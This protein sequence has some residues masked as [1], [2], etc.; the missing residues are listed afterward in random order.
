MSD[1]KIDAEKAWNLLSWNNEVQWF[2]TK[3]EKTQVYIPPTSDFPNTRGA[4]I[5]TNKRTMGGRLRSLD[6]LIGTI[7]NAEALKWNI[8]LNANP[9]NPTGKTKLSRDD[10]TNWRYIVVDLDPGEDAL[11]PPGP[12]ISAD[13]TTDG[14]PYL[15]DS[16]L[17]HAHRIFSGRGY[18]YWLRVNNSPVANSTTGYLRA[19]EHKCIHT[20]LAADWERIMQGYLRALKNCS[21]RWAPGWIV[22]TTCSDLARVV[23]CPGSVNQKTGRRATVEHIAEKGIDIEALLCYNTPLAET[24]SCRRCYSDATL[25]ETLPHMNITARKFILEGASSPGRHTACFATAKNLQE[26]GVSRDR[27]FEWLLIGAG[28]CWGKEWRTNGWILEQE[29]YGEA[30]QQSLP[31]HE[32]ERIVNQVYGR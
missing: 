32:V 21:E 14:K 29:M 12:W 19:D 30:F 18:Q 2:A 1:W 13:Y 6:A 11:T 3:E 10:I 28:K 26:L 17:L 9:S 24:P 15:P 23:R 27:A 5:N 16:Y 8:Y 4:K 7:R 22:D 25:M 31:Q 20:Y